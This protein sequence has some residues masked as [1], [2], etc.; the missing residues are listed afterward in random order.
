MAAKHVIRRYLITGLLVWL[1][2]GVTFL[3]LRFFIEFLDGIFSFLPTHYQPQQLLGHYIPGLG[4]IFALII[5][6]VTGLLTSNFLGRQL[7]QAWEKILNRIPLIRSIYTATKQVTHAFVKPQGKAFRKVVL[8]EYPRKG[9]WSIAFLTADTFHLVPHDQSSQ[10]V[11]IPTTP[12]PTSGF[13][14]LAP[15]TDIIVLD[16]SIED[17]FKM[18]ISLGTVTP[19]TVLTKAQADRHTDS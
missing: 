15:K 14:I 10:A 6:L 17:A 19:E 3:V 9:V 8:V 1:P 11:F 4:L 2:V 16:I 7:I 5:I 18:I 13:L 12:N